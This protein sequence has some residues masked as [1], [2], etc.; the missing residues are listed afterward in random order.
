MDILWHTLVVRKDHEGGMCT[1]AYP[2]PQE[3]TCVTTVQ[4][5]NV[6]PVTPDAEAMEAIARAIEERAQIVASTQSELLEAQRNQDILD[7]Q[8]FYAE[9]R[10]CMC[11]CMLACLCVCAHTHVHAC[12]RACT[13]VCVRTCMCACVCV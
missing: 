5:E 3:V 11:V 4:V 9:V 1:P 13:W 7:E 10:V 12:M 6:R 2:V 8:E